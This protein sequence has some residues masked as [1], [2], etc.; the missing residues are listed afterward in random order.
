MNNT[1]QAYKPFGS[2]VIPGYIMQRPEDNQNES[3]LF[4]KKLRKNLI[5]EKPTA[6]DIFKSTTNPQF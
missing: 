2:D 3:P 4:S 6:I 1:Y 5:L